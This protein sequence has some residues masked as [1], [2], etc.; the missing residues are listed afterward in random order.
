M[1]LL[2]AIETAICR[3]QPYVAI[4]TS[5]WATRAELHLHMVHANHLISDVNSQSKEVI[6]L[7]NSKYFKEFSNSTWSKQI[8]TLN[9]ETREWKP[10]SAVVIWIICLLLNTLQHYFPGCSAH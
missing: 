2:P 7:F 5:T 4:T 9:I 1:C 6:E 3:A 8:T 10:R